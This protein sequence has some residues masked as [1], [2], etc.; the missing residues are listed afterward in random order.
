VAAHAVAIGLIG[1]ALTLW[2][3]AS[4]VIARPRRDDGH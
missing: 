2:G 1:A 3:V 4:L